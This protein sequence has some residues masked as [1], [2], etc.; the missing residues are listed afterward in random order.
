[1]RWPIGSRC[2]LTSNTICVDHLIT[3][4]IHCIYIYI[5]QI[6]KTTPRKNILLTAYTLGVSEIKYKYS[7]SL[8]VE[9]NY[10]SSKLIFISLFE[11]FRL[12]LV[13]FSHRH[14]FKCLQ[15]VEGGILSRINTPL[16]SKPNNQTSNHDQLV[17]KNKQ[18]YKQPRTDPPPPLPPQQKKK[19]Q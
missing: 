14:T 19:E 18:Q 5:L 17:E 13:F 7:T 9:I 1:M 16:S 10:T 15:N 3:R 2:E 4:T 8:R 6:Y 11:S 12:C